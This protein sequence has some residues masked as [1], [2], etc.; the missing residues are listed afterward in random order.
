MGV[1]ASQC[2]DINHIQPTTAAASIF[3]LLVKNLRRLLTS[4]NPYRE[5]GPAYQ[6]KY[7]DV[8]MYYNKLIPVIELPACVKF[9][10]MQGTTRT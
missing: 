2:S 4:W 1:K 9:V 6:K 8:E 7:V 5:N 3:K 10:V